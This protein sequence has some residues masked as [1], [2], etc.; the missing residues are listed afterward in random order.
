ME[1]SGI[2][3]DSDFERLKS[4]VNLQQRNQCNK[5]TCKSW[6]SCPRDKSKLMA[7]M[8]LRDT[9]LTEMTLDESDGDDR[10]VE[11]NGIQLHS[12]HQA[13]WG[14]KLICGKSKDCN[15][16]NIKRREFESGYNCEFSQAVVDNKNCKGAPPGGNP[17]AATTYMQYESGICEQQANPNTTA[18]CCQ[19]KIHAQNSFKQRKWKLN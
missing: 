12:F 7:C 2:L 3:S 1:K 19:V 4:Q 18:S 14:C 8:P 6:I 15:S 9:V 13:V 10:A 5:L 16:F 11:W 17:Y